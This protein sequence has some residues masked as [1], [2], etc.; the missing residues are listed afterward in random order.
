MG[1]IVKNSDVVST[2]FLQSS[3]F[4]ARRIEILNYRVGYL[5]KLKSELLGRFKKLTLA[6]PQMKMLQ[7]SKPLQSTI[8][9]VINLQTVQCAKA[10]KVGE[11]TTSAPG[12]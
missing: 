3:N 6:I 8:R 2:R 10:K 7:L 9:Q 5:I 11:E 1:T 12:G 4:F